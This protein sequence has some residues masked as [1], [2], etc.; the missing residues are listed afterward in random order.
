MTSLRI[1]FII[2]WWESC[3]QSRLPRLQARRPLTSLPSQ[4]P[5]PLSSK[6]LTSSTFWRV[7][8]FSNLSISPASLSAPCFE[9]A[10]RSQCPPRARLGRSRRHCTQAFETRSKYAPIRVNHMRMTVF[11]TTPATKES[12]RLSWLTITSPRVILQQNNLRNSQEYAL[13]PHCGRETRQIR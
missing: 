12:L 9:V 8:A 1:S 5:T 10:C 7:T 2:E 3:G 13:K 11:N 4:S 6:P